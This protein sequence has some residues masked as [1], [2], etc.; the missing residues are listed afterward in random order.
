[1]AANKLQ[2]GDERL[3]SVMIVGVGQRAPGGKHLFWTAAAEWLQSNKSN[4]NGREA[5]FTVHV[6]EVHLS[7]FESARQRPVRDFLCSGGANLD[8]PRAIH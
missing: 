8:I 7:N 4:N 2:V 6:Q 3:C 1:M 5:V